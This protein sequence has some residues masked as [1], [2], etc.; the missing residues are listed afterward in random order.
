MPVH[1]S[2]KRSSRPLVHLAAALSSLAALLATT[3]APARAGVANAGIA[4]AGR[5]NPLTGLSWG[6]YSGPMDEVF[7]AFRDAQGSARRLLARVALAPRMRWFGDW[8]ADDQAESVARQYI[9][10]ATGGDPN[11]LVQM[12]VFRLKPWERA[13]CQALPTP[14]EQA[15]Y[16]AWIDAFAAGIGDARVALVLQPDLPFA[17]CTPHHSLLPL[18]LVAYAARVFGALPHTSVY[19]DAGAGDWPSVGQASWLLRNAGIRSGRG[20]ALNAT[21]YDSTENEIRFGARVARALAAAGFPG[22]HFVVNTSTNGRGFTYQQYHDPASFDNA[23]V[24]STRASRRC[25]TLGIPPTTDVANRRWG[26]SSTARRLAVRYADAYMWIGRPWLYN[27]A[28]PFDLRRTLMLAAT[29][30]F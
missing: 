30:P 4:R 26:L 12:A 28:S 13:A 20:F 29:T 7:P 2:I 27:Q 23:R 1:L 16:K 5:A 11:V 24:C 15:S 9:A 25:A 8:Y 21:H 14:A 19:I 18:H 17:S 6:N 3:G 22:K 10:N